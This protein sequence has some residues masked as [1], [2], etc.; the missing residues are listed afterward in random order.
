MCLVGIA[1][2]QS[3]ELYY[4]MRRQKAMPIFWRRNFN[5]SCQV[6]TPEGITVTSKHFATSLL[7]T[8]A[9]PFGPPSAGSMTQPIVLM[10]IDQLNTLILVTASLT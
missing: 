2:M 9:P 1:L 5:K 8:R 6:R 3:V 4:F 7:H 10:F